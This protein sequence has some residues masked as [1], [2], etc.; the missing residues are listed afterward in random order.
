M[1]E[2]ANIV[3]SS[4]V[5]NRRHIGIEIKEIGGWL[6][7]VVYMLHVVGLVV[8]TLSTVHAAGEVE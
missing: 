5:L 6:I 3:Y 2:R 8:L 1:R 7:C 4:A